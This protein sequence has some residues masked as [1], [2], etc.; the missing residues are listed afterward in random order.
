MQPHLLQGGED[1]VGVPNIVVLVGINLQG[2]DVFLEVDDD[3]KS[4]GRS[5]MEGRKEDGKSGTNL[6]FIR[7][8]HQLEIK[9][10]ELRD[11]LRSK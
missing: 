3:L 6:S 11:N 5:E 1:S 8:F 7:A 9:H 4:K 2:I 10:M